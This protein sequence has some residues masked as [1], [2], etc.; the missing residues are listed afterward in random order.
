MLVCAQDS[1]IKARTGKLNGKETLRA[2]SRVE[3][4]K[5]KLSSKKSSFAQRARDIH[6]HAIDF[7]MSSHSKRWKRARV[8]SPF[9][10][11]FFVQKSRTIS[12]GD[13]QTCEAC[14]RRNDSS[15]H[16]YSTVVT[17]CSCEVWR[18]HTVSCRGDIHHP[19]DRFLRDN[20]RRS[21]R[22]TLHLSSYAGAD[23]RGMYKRPR[24]RREIV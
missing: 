14:A 9:S 24:R 7:S 8:S 20:V 16:S 22:R 21:C 12:R 5:R 15:T 13:R 23:S 10:S 17:S 18:R 19:A 1:Q 2:R 3:R 11:F 4:E 6:P